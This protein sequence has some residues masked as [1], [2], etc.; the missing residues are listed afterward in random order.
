[1]TLRPWLRRQNR[2]K[3]QQ[4]GWRPRLPLRLE[5]LEDRTLLSADPLSLTDP[6]LWGDTGRFASSKPA[7][8]SDGQIVV[9]QSRADNLVANDTNGAIDVFAYDR[10]RGTLQLVSVNLAGTASAD[11]DSTD[12][13]VSADGRYV[14]FTSGASNLTAQTTFREQ[15]YVRDLQTGTTTLASIS[16]SGTQ[17]TNAACFN[18]SISD[19]GRFVTFDTTGD[20][21]VANDTNVVADAYLRDLQTNTT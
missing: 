10:S 17:G 2:S 14:L 12:A 6:S 1:M 19:D 8:S 13:R 5:Q 16:T 3:P 7:I 21:L 15:I 9:F 20:N 18:A 4:G 11:A